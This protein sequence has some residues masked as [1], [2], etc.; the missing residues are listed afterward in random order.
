MK[1]HNMQFVRKSQT[2]TFYYTLWIYFMT[3]HKKKTKMTQTLM[4]E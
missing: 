4:E 1:E 3:T 2:S